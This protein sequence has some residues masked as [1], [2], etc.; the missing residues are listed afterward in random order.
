M[1]AGLLRVAIRYLLPLAAAGAVLYLSYTFA[2]DRGYAKR[3]T[4]AVIAEGRR[5]ADHAVALQL[6]Q[7]RI[8]SLLAQAGERDEAAN[9]EKR[10][11]QKR[12]DDLLAQLR[13]AR[14]RF[15]VPVVQP[16]CRDPADPPAVGVQ[17]RAELDPAAAIELVGITSDGDDA[18]RDLNRCIDAY[19]AVR[20]TYGRR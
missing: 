7:D 9:K 5:A 12:T 4:E 15:S 8:A 11:A 6:Q 3:N 2:F 19:N 14:V 1:Y 16:V 13:S 18:I 20:I 10:D 17:A